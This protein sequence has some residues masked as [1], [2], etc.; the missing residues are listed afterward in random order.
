MRKRS[1]PQLR[2]TINPYCWMFRV[3]RGYM[4]RLRVSISSYV[5]YLMARV[6]EVNRIIYMCVYY[7]LR[8][9]NIECCPFR[10]KDLGGRP[11]IFVIMA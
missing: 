2:I 8:D 5:G 4:P 6:Y 3:R 9:F 10:G 7:L 11:H 1:I